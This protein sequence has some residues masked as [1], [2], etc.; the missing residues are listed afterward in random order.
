M[1]LLLRAIANGS[2]RALS[3][4][5]P[6]RPN[7]AAPG[8][9][10]LASVGTPMG[11]GVYERYATSPMPE[12]A[13]PENPRADLSPADFVQHDEFPEPKQ[14]A[15]IAEM[16]SADLKASREAQ[17]PH[18]PAWFD[19]MQF[20]LGSQWKRYNAQTGKYHDVRSKPSPGSYFQPRY[21]EYNKIAPL[22]EKTISKALQSKQDATISPL[23]GSE[24]DLSAARQARSVVSHIDRLYDWQ[25]MLTEAAEWAAAVAP[26]LIKSYW[27]PNKTVP[28]PIYGA[29]GQVA[30]VV[31]VKAGEIVREIVSPFKW[32]G[33]PKAERF[34]DMGY[35]IHVQLVPLD[36]VQK[37][38]PLGWKIKAD[39]PMTDETGV[40]A[41]VASIVGDY[42][43]IASSGPMGVEVVEY[44]EKASVRFPAG[45]L[46]TMAN[47][48]LIS[49]AERWPDG[50]G[51]V[52][53]FRPL[54]F[55]KAI[56]SIHGINAS[57]GLIDGQVLYNKGM[58]R[59]EEWV[60]GAT[61]CIM[62]EEGTE[63]DIDVMR[64]NR[65]ATVYFYKNPKASANPVSIQQTPGMPPD[66][67][68]MMSAAD[69][70]M[71]DRIGIHQVSDGLTPT[72]VDSGVAI[73]LLKQGDDT[74]GALFLTNINTLVK[75]VAED[76]ILIARNKYIEPRLVMV[77]DTQL[78]DPDAPRAQAMVFRELSEGR[79]VVSAGS[80]VPKDP[81]LR[82][83]QIL[84]MAAKGM[85]NPD[86]LRVTK[87]LLKAMGI[88]NS[89]KLHDDFDALL[90]EM[91]AKQPTPEQQQAAEQQHQRQM[92]ADQLQVKQAMQQLDLQFKGALSQLQTEN[93][94][95][96]EAV[97]LHSTEATKHLEAQLKIA[98]EQAFRN[99]VPALAPA[100][101]DPAA[102][103]E[104]ERLHGIR[105][106]IPTPTIQPAGKY[107]SAQA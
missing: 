26:P 34:E 57:S 52:F 29:D 81:I 41:R 77:Q 36:F 104:I 46:M 92:L 72:G 43:R 76:T 8:L 12:L 20:Y 79:V 3:A 33:D 101:P 18:L 22:V 82:Q 50:D 96:L 23:T 32:L 107:T 87:L 28:I 51:T 93:A 21:R 70:F 99:M 40:N 53:Q 30:R 11:S 65:L 71:R 13:D 94:A 5:G 19:G 2:K 7:V 102:T 38:Y 63:P 85:F 103:V 44:W 10:G 88:E 60:D 39:A 16:I 24:L 105:G 98:V 4:A 95:Q 90:K 78:A 80:S 45:R 73:Q 47:G 61:W 84:D 25:T 54:W 69:D 17:S 49:Y 91:E 31:D 68:T 56:G 37:T 1:S 55:K 64:S 67:L 6:Q 83:Q 59:A 62:A 74:Q 48:I 75:G 86:N 35:L 89:D 97:K 106:A 14:A 15:K 66:F 100:S 9:P 27:N 58:S 42:G